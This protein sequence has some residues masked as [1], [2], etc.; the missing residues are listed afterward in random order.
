MAHWYDG[1]PLKDNDFPLLLVRWITKEYL[2]RRNTSQ[3]T[4]RYQPHKLGCF[5]TNNDHRWGMMGLWTT[6]NGGTVKHGIFASQNETSSHQVQRE[7]VGHEWIGRGF[8][9]IYPTK[10]FWPG[11]MDK[12]L[13]A[14]Q[15]CV[16]S[17]VGPY[18][19]NQGV[20]QTVAIPEGELLGTAVESWTMESSV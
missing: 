16:D 5:V 4:C 8:S 10:R 19:K 12:L 9:D 1:L 15:P 3:E 11:Q 17:E 13:A 14:C 20:P 6:R 18:N 2:R 7:I